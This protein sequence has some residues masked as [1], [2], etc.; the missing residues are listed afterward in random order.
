MAEAITAARPYAEAVFRLAQ[1]RGELARWSEM[2]ALLAAVAADERIVPLAMDPRVPRERL[3]TLLLDI[4]GDGLNVHGSNFVRLLAENRRIQ[5]LPEIRALFE[6][7]SAEAEGRVEATVISAF[8]LDQAQQAK[9]AQ[10]LKRKLGREVSLT[11]QIDR[12]LLGGVVIRA[13]DLVIDGSASGRL[14]ALASHLN[15]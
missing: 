11:T 3:V 4:C 9:L 13:G 14:R 10:A 12:G 5:L 1:E 2:L 8:P 7:L 6:T 15:R